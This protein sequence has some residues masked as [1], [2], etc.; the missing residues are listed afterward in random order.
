M[1][2][3]NANRHT[4]NILAQKDYK[5]S[6]LVLIPIDHGYSL[7]QNGSQL[8]PGCRVSDTWS[9]LLSCVSDQR[10]AYTSA[11][12]GEFKVSADSS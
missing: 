6:Q 1:R 7:P 5:D 9:D 11:L 4:G 12:A 2:L 8:R 3:A 10:V